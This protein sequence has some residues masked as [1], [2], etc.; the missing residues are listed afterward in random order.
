VL[1]EKRIDNL[2]DEI[3]LLKGELKNSLASVRDY[4]L[5]MELPSSEFSTIL[6]ALSGDAPNTQKMAADSDVSNKGEDMPEP[7]FD[8][9]KPEEEA[10]LTDE[11]DQ[12]GENEDLL[13]FEEPGKEE[14]VSEELPYQDALDKE[15]DMMA[16]DLLPEETEE[17][18]DTLLP[19][20]EAIETEEVTTPEAELP[21]E[22]AHPSEY[23]RL[24]N[25][26]TQGI[27]KVNMLANLISW[28]A[29]A[30]QDIGNEE[31]PTF[32]EVY[33]IS[34]HLSPELKDIIMRLA[35]VAKDCPDNATDSEIWSQSMLSLHGILTGG[36][37]PMNPVIPS[38]VDTTD[39]AVKSL[40]DE[41][42]EIDKAKEKSAK[43]KLVFPT[44]NGKS[45]EFCIDLTPEDSDN[46]SA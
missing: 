6:A 22:E 39:E 4:L 15:D 12:P 40:E 19:E 30:K 31:L 38:W 43:L 45:K 20:D 27:P 21:M 9:E 25:E 5:N 24:I 46:G 23:D 16:E 37:A 42:I 35:E 18:E 8:E 14:E 26:A 17:A 2:Q 28:V 29:K 33:G 3:K 32:L 11:L 1:D 7:N 36:D 34:G 13:D 41:I 44:G 10:G